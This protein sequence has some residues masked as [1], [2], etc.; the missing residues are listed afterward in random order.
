MRTVG[1]FKNSEIRLDSMH[2]SGTYSGIYAMDSYAEAN[3]TIIET[4][5]L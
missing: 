4:M 5:N 1:D 3:D 2:L